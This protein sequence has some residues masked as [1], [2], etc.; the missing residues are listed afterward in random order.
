MTPPL[1]YHPW[2]HRWAILTAA[3]VFPLLAVGGLVTSWRVGMID[4]Q[5]LREPWHLADVLQE[6][7]SPENRLAFLIEHG[8]RT[9]GWVVGVL[10]IV[11]AAWTVKADP[12]PGVRKLAVA[13]LVGVALQG[14]LGILR[15]R[16]QPEG[17]GTEFAMTHGV[18]GQIVFCLLAVTAL[19]LSASWGEKVQAVT[20]PK[21]ARFRRLCR[22][23]VFLMLIQL[24]VG[25]W[26]RQKGQGPGAW[27]LWLHLFF[28]L[29]VLTHVLL[30]AL[31]IFET[32]PTP[33]PLFRRPAAVMIGLVVLQ[34]LLG[35]GAWMTGGAQGADAF[36]AEQPITLALVT[37]ATAHVGTGALL[38]MT[39]VLLTVRAFR[40]L[41]VPAQA[42]PVPAGTA[43][44]TA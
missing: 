39:T 24:V 1:T 27:A 25:V 21:P 7:L 26:L 12:R 38:L 29:A 23:T 43:E 34:V 28:A 4:P 30:L 14:I 31:R 6:D 3:A 10:A 36:T 8:H 16:F 11:L 22:L 40:H 37:W 9:L 32:W 35:V 18:V 13:G 33:E 42:A 5:G 2:L 41:D 15:V 44:G 19:T 20:V 17:M